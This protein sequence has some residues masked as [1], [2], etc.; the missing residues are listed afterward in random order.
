MLEGDHVSSLGLTCRTPVR[1][2]GLHWEDRTSLLDKLLENVCL[3]LKHHVFELCY[4]FSILKGL[5][6]VLDEG[7]V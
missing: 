4:L 3:L 1:I 2:E 7:A 5:V 6:L